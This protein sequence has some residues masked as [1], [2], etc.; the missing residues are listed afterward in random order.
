MS[1]AQ[2]A[3]VALL[4]FLSASLARS[5]IYRWTDASGREHF[6]TNL[7]DVPPA[8]RPK[9]ASAEPAPPRQAPST[10]PASMPQA[11]SG[12]LQRSGHD[13]RSAALLRERLLSGR[14]EAY[15]VEPVSSVWAV[16]METGYPNGAGTLVTRSD[17]S[18]DLILSVG[19]GVIGGRTLPEINARARQLVATA[20]AS[21]DELS[22]ASE[23]PLPADG[24]VRFY[25]LTTQGVRTARAPRDEIA[26]S[27]HPLSE[28]FLAGHAVLTELRE[29]SEAAEAQGR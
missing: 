5:E 16:L 20:A 15:R 10:P 9:G 25:V 27:G 29:A 13:A 3:A 6:T 17:G 21:L 1:R 19:G 4:V 8:Q 22:P 11:G 28:L 24:E 23:F 12:G 18:A 26:R 14:P 7:H 2:L